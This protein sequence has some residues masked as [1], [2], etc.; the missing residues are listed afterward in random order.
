MPMPLKFGSLSAPRAVGKSH[1]TTA[2]KPA[3]C[4]MFSHPVNQKN[5]Y[6]I[7]EEEIGNQDGISA[8]DRPNE[9]RVGK[10]LIYAIGQPRARVPHISTDVSPT[11]RPSSTVL[12]LK[13]NMRSG[14]WVCQ[15]E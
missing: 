13:Q 6:L 12:S 14:L 4:P 11:F 1:S 8:R 7:G 9:T 3:M 15:L 2:A 5:E 10:A